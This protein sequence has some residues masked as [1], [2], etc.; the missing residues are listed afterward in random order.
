MKKKY[1]ATGVIQWMLNDA[2]PKI[3]WH[4]YDFYLRPGGGYF[5]TKKACEPLH[6]QYSYDDRSVVVVNGALDGRRGLKATARV[7]DLGSKELFSKTAPVDIGP[8]ASTKVFAVPEPAGITPSVLPR[9]DA[10]RRGRA[11]PSAATSIGSRRNP[12]SSSGPSRSGTTRR[13]RR[14][15]TTPA[16]NSSRRPTCRRRP[17]SRAAGRG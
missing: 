6:V 4:L 1:R 3:I 17:G 2:W 5:G 15:P 10:R 16:C 14:T 8:D 12:T 11:A 13:S 7:L 9:P